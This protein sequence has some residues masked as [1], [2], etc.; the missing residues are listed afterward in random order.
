MIRA[1]LQEIF[2]RKPG[3]YESIDGIRALAVI[4]VIFFHALFEW[5][6]FVSSEAYETAVHSPWNWLW[7]KGYLAINPFFIISGFLIGDLLLSE[8]E[9]RG[10]IEL[11]SFYLRRFFRLAPAYYLVLAGFVAYGFYD[12]TLYSLRTLW[13][14][15][16]YVNNWLPHR[17]QPAIWTWS[18]AVEEQFYIL[19][20]LFILALRRK[21]LP[22]GKV[23]LALI[24]LSIAW[25]YRNAVVH[26]PFKVL[27]R[28]ADDLDGY[29]RF[30]DFTYAKTTT[31]VSALLLGVGCAFLKRDARWMARL[32][33]PVGTFAM[34]FAFLAIS[35][36]S[37]NPAFLPPGGS[38]SKPIVTALFNPLSAFSFACLVMLLQTKR[39]FG[40]AADRF[41]GAGVWYP[42]AQ[43]AYGLYLL[44][45]P[46]VDAFYKLFPPGPSIDFGRLTL[47][48]CVILAVTFGA[49][50][51]LNLFVEN[52][53]RKF[54]YRLAK[55]KTE[56]GL[57]ESHVA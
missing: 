29:F 44:H 14:N 37:F 45:C 30:F 34:T 35:F 39:G 11:K 46:V 51:V 17:G 55:R 41:L 16:I 42:V 22:A 7:T 40:G 5:G 6:N 8:F 15:L 49:A 48:G 36:V 12:P 52:P 10:A 23:I 25:N 3:R 20:P 18:L 28:P 33:S 32:S 31:R 38:F 1:G 54:G 50:I 27:Y 43:V 13:A 26:G 56:N 2:R 24:V 21:A 47:N 4:W 53:M 19:C 9:R 57:R